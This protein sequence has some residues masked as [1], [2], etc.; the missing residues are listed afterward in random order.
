MYLK[1]GEQICATES[2][3]KTIKKA[4]LRFRIHKPNKLWKHD[5]IC[6]RCFFKIAN[7]RL[8]ELNTV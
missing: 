2:C 7:T 8:D 1:K 3:K 4:E 6:G 5:W